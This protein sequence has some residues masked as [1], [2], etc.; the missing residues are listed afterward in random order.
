MFKYIKTRYENIYEWSESGEGTCHYGDIEVGKYMYWTG[1]NA[2]N[3]YLIL[4]DEDIE[5]LN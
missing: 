3:F 1:C 5:L 2:D 4:S